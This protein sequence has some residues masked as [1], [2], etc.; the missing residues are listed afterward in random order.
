MTKG[1]C[2]V[3]LAAGKGMRMKSSR[4]KV[5]H[6]VCG[7]PMLHY[8]LTALSRLGIRQVVTVIGHCQAQIRPVF[9]S[10]NAVFVEQKELLGTGHA[11]MCGLKGLKGF[12]GDVLV[13]SGDTPLVTV[14]TIKAFIDFHKRKG[15][16]ISFVTALLQDPSGYGRVLRNAE[17]RVIK[18]VEHKDASPSERA[19]CEINAGIYLVQSGF[20]FDNIK[21][22]GSK[23]AQ[24]EYYL[25]EL[26]GL[27]VADGKGAVAMTHTDP[28]EVMGVNNRVELAR[29]NRLMQR[30]IT[31]ALMLSGV[32]ITDPG[33]VY[34]DDGVTI[35]ADTIIRPGATLTGKT[36]VGANVVIGQGAIIKDSVIG[37]GSDIRPYSVLDSCK[38]GKGVTIGPF[39]RI[40]PE[41]VIRDFASVGNFVEVK[42]SRLGKGA[43]ANHLSYIGDSII[44]KD[45]NIGAGVITCNYDG[46]EKHTTTIEDGAFIGSDSQLI[47]PVTIKKG[48][49]VGSGTT[50]T[51]DVPRDS[52]VVTRAKETVIRDWARKTA[53]RRGD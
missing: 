5:L 29:A 42:K 41:T 15:A 38:T 34:I 23:N 26:V 31:D 35:G 19:V 36:S 7:R 16:A 45:V 49:Y 11:L 43:K 3:V 1:V 33:A 48:A 27:A 46:V 25:P 50:V 8:P 18:I 13:L 28:D 39:A 10:Y 17:N 2:A 20:L 32:G 53:R 4:A 47:A 24:R 40:R 21:R 14:D 44:G 51:K 30:R 12:K 22:L 9:S 37:D 6:E 52:L